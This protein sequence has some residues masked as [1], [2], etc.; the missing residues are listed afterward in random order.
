[1]CN[2]LSGAPQLKTIHELNHDQSYANLPDN[3]FHRVAPEGLKDPYIIDFNEHAAE[4]INLSHDQKNDADFLAYMSGNK[5]MPGTTP[6]AAVYSG[7]QFGHYVPQLGDGRAVLLTEIINEDGS[8]WDLQLKG[9]GLTAFSRQGDG[10]A[11]LRST[12]REYLCSE[13]M[14]HLGIP[15]TRGLCIIG[16]DTDVYRERIEKGAMI[17][18]MAPSHIRFGTVQYFYHTNQHEMLTTLLDYLINMHYPEFRDSAT[19]Y[20]ELLEAIVIRTAKLMAQW[21]SVGFAHGVMNTDN[22]SVLGLTMDY[23]PFGFLDN[24]NPKYICNHSDPHGRYAF[25]QQP[26]IGLW[27]LT[28]LAEAF[29]PLIRIDSAKEALGKYEAAYS[30][31]YIDIMLKKLGFAQYQPE[32]L[33]LIK[34]LLSQMEESNADYTITLRQLSNFDAEQIKQPDSLALRDSFINRD[35]FDVWAQAYAAALKA[36]NQPAF[37]KKKK[38]DAANPKFILRNHLA[39]IAIEK[40][41]KGDYEELKRLKKILSK[42]FDEQA[43]YEEYASHP[44]EWAQHIEISCSS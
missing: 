7:H 1:M 30:N 27:N 3:F 24:Y 29:T 15:T 23:G 19:K 9:A 28:C 35:K 11:V 33:N 21:Q 2:Q 34:D 22:M 39:Q 14:H 5:V 37:L 12:V 10:R 8:R 25:D 18:R 36:E 41:E 26:N 13:A 4:L 40:A 43:E 6:L 38:M 16:S 32:H 20:E 31:T 42:P 44:P 17:T